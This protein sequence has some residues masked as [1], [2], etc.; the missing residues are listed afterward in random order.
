MLIFFKM[1]VFVKVKNIVLDAV[2]PHQCIC[3]KLD[4]ILCEE[5][6][7][8]IPRNKTQLCPKCKKISENGKTCSSCRQKSSLTGV[9]I[10]GDHEG[11]LKDAIWRYKYYLI[12][13]LDRPLSKLLVSRFGDYIKSKNLL[14][15]SV[16]ISKSRQR[17]RGF[18]QS[19][20]MATKLSDELGLVSSVLLRR[21]GKSKSQVGL[22]RKERIKNLSGG[23]GLQ[24][25]IDKKFLLNKKILIVDDVY[26]T[27]STL[28]ECAKTLRQSGARE[29]WGIVLTRD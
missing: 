8:K 26:T 29:V 1:K 24:E 7:E 23:F 13:D 11:A 9:M 16:P 25:S 22:T 19:E 10:F 5:C 6:L 27:G 2:F 28:E 12:R 15:T 3:G 21:N 17:W 4:S 14:I 18:N 20:L